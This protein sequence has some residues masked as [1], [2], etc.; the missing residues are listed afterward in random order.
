VHL[1]IGPTKDPTLPRREIA[2]SRPVPPGRTSIALAPVPEAD[3]LPHPEVGAQLSTT[4]LGRG[5]T[6]DFTFDGVVVSTLNFRGSYSRGA[7]LLP[8]TV[9]LQ[10]TC[11]CTG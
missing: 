1:W 3:L 8:T 5:P 4:A 9:M 7:S 11:T 10:P 6:K 2:R